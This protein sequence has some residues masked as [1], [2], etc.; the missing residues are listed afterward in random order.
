MTDVIDVADSGGTPEYFALIRILVDDQEIE[1]RP[2]EWENDAEGNPI[3]AVAYR[4]TCPFCSQLTEFKKADLRDNMI[5]CTECRRGEVEWQM[6]N[7][8][9]LWE[10]S[11]ASLP[12]VPGVP[13][14]QPMMILEPIAA[15]LMEA[16]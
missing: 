5:F 2:Y 1:A 6:K 7:N 15:G 8:R 12:A 4:T 10:K 13:A 3:A 16:P 11:E 14:S 9:L